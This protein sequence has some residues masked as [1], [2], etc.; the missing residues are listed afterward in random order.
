M[1]NKW[2][3]ALSVLSIGCAAA[4]DKSS[5]GVGPGNGAADGGGNG[6]GGESAGDNGSGGDTP[7]CAS[8]TF[9]ADLK[10]SALV[11]QLDTSGSM[12]CPITN[13]VA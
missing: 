13:P 5:T 4:S 10:P 11:F 1:R 7:A 6:N 12:N 8:D 2:I 3:L 9:F